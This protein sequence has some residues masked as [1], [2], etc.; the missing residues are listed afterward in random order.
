MLLQITPPELFN[1]ETERIG[2]LLVEDEKIRI[3]FSAG[4]LSE[5]TKMYLD[6][7]RLNRYLRILDMELERTPAT[8]ELDSSKIIDYVKMLNNMNKHEGK[9]A[10]LVFRSR[11]KL[12]KSGITDNIMYDEKRHQQDV[13]FYDDGYQIEKRDSGGKENINDWSRSP[14]SNK[15]ALF[16]DSP[17]EN[18]K[19]ASFNEYSVSQKVDPHL[20]NSKLGRDT[21]VNQY[22]KNGNYELNSDLGNQLLVEKIKQPGNEK[23]LAEIP[24]NKYTGD[25]FYNIDSEPLDEELI[26]N[27]EIRIQP[28][29]VTEYSFLGSAK[30]ERGPQ[31]PVRNNQVLDLTD[32]VE[33]NENPGSYENK[34]NKDQSL[35]DSPFDVPVPINHVN[36]KYVSGRDGKSANTYGKR[37]IELED[38]ELEQRIRQGEMMSHENET[39]FEINSA[40][41]T[42]GG[43]NKYV[44][45]DTVGSLLTNLQNKLYNMQTPTN[46]LSRVKDNNASFYQQFLQ[47][48]YNNMDLQKAIEFKTATFFRNYS[49]PNLSS[50][51]PPVKSDYMS[52]VPSDHKIFPLK[53]EDEIVNVPHMK[54][55]EQCFNGENNNF[56]NKRDMPTKPAKMYSKYYI[57]RLKKLQ[58]YDDDSGSLNF[59][60]QPRMPLFGTKESEVSKILNVNLDHLNIDKGALYKIIGK[61]LKVDEE[62]PQHFAPPKWL[63]NKY[64]ELLHASHRGQNF[65]DY[66]YIV[67]SRHNLNLDHLLSVRDRKESVFQRNNTSI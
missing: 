38:A 12:M 1:N 67:K 47:N 63:E 49:G 41:G 19:F 44:N 40:N 3:P 64:E 56:Q 51:E 13:D 36:S 5:V 48:M 34:K 11:I 25:E 42:G 46:K 14:P 28:S 55:F 29:S 57:S 22:I 66:D 6:Q 24:V 65:N 52:N 35:F 43:L 27:F 15:N 9:S 20:D 50:T 23:N 18:K 54:Y 26:N 4:G 17:I 39:K 30:V 45:P 33:V 62:N 21:A 2:N 59:L 60:K 31:E 37:Q 58:K 7:N 32:K 10:D 53:P 61:A 8:I 16:F